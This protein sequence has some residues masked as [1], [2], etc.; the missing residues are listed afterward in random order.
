MG[1]DVLPLMA[2]YGPDILLLD[3]SMPQSK[4]A[5][6]GTNFYASPVIKEIRQRWPETGII[7]LTQQNVPALI[8]QS[9]KWGVAG[10]ILKGDDLSLQLPTA[11]DMVRKGA[12]YF[13]E[14]V[15]QLL[16][17]GNDEEHDTHLTPRQMEILTMVYRY[18][19]DSSQQHARTLGIKDGTYRSHLS[20]AYKALG[21]TND[22][23]AIIRCL[24]LGFFANRSHIAA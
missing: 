24:E 8:H 3:L 7:I 5:Q 21:V 18:P 15:S 11:I 14:S 1:D 22:T 10:Y 19:D 20:S 23:A 9:V 6:N 13:S 12:V 2:R 17:R 4:N 16:Y